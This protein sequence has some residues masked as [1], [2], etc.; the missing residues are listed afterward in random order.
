MAWLAVEG[1]DEQQGASL[2]DE[3]STEQHGVLSYSYSY[4]DKVTEEKRRRQLARLAEK[5]V[6]EDAVI[7]A[8]ITAVLDNLVEHVAWDNC[9]Q[10]D[11]LKERGMQVPE[12]LLEIPAWCAFR[13]LNWAVLPLL[14][15]LC[16]NSSL[17]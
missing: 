2:L 8:E 3:L 6:T 9:P 4:E 17:H 1:L 15:S 12:D 11:G 10:G 5:G 14:S 16:E 7:S 13:D